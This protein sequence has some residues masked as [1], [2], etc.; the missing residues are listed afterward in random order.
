MTSVFK[1]QPTNAYCVGL[2]RMMAGWSWDISCEYC[3]SVRIRREIL[4]AV[5]GQTGCLHFACDMT[6]QAHNRK[7]MQGF[8]LNLYYYMGTVVL[9]LYTHRCK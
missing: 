6:V 7:T 5:Y 4:A 3:R 8:A 1:S 2:S 9:Y